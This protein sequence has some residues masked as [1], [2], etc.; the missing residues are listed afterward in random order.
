MSESKLWDATQIGT[1]WLEQASNALSNEDIHAFCDLMLLGGWMRG[2]FS[3][4]SSAIHLL[5]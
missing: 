1:E 5:V 4:A 3:A 2:K